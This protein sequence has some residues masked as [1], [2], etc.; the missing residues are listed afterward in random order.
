MAYIENPNSSGLF[1]FTSKELLYF[2]LKIYKIQTF[3]FILLQ[4]G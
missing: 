4:V 3:S 1:N 2:S